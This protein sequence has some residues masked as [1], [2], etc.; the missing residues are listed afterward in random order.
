MLFCS[1]FSQ[2]RTVSIKAH[3]GLP[4]PFWGQMSSNMT[5]VGGYYACGANAANRACG[6]EREIA[7]CRNIKGEIK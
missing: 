4:G 6:R 2:N 7:R 3:T 5:E 1:K